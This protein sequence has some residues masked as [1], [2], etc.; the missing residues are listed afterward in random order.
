MS[1]SPVP[2]KNL[3]NIKFKNQINTKLI[4]QILDLNSKIVI[5][6]LYNNGVSFKDISLDLSTVISGNYILNVSDGQNIVSNK[7]IIVK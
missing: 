3:L 6:S 5:S 2:T 4:I 1:L 7:L